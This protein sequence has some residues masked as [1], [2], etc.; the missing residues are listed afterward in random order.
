MEF[1]NSSEEG[2]YLGMSYII[3]RPK[4][5]ALK[6]IEDLV[7]K[8]VASWSGKFTSHEGREVLA[9]HV[10]LALLIYAMAYVKIL[11]G[12]YKELNSLIAK[13]F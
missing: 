6:Y 10:L 12:L 13:F 11:V 8:K 4:R 3:G 2:K 7:M 5:D 9:K 1:S